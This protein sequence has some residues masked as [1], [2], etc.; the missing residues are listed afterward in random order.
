MK[1][2]SPELYA[3]NDNA[4]FLI[5]DWLEGKGY[6]AEINPDQYG[7]DILARGKGRTLRVEVEVKHNW[8]TGSFKY[9]TLQIPQRK[10]KFA[11][12][13][14]TWFVVMNHDRTHALLCSGES[15]LSSDLVEVPNKLVSEG[16][17]FFQIPVSQCFLITF[18]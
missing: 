8:M 5:V 6:A 12:D 13:P 18:P 15:V 17:R 1:P 9:D 4:K 16:E 14:D 10:A 3:T 2:F 7:I 11:K